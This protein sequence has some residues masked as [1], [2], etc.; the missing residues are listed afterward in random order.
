MAYRFKARRIVFD[1]D[2]TLVDTAP[3]LCRAMNHVLGEVGRPAV[4]VEQVR[5]MVGQGARKL[6]E[7]GL[8]ATGGLGPDIEIERLIAVFLDHYGANIAAASRPFDG[9][10]ALLERL[11]AQ[12]AVLGL[13]TNKPQALAEALM[14][15]LRLDGF[16]ASMVGGDALAQRKPHPMHLG[17]V[18]SDLGDGPAVMI[19]DTAT[20]VGAARNAAVPVFLA[21][22]GYSAEPA[23]S[24]GGDAVFADFHELDTWLEVTR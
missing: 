17:R 7:R 16:F 18:L 9:A 24:L 14:S 8:Q 15:E 11:S 4:P 12:G 13:C 2:G 20:D 19:G 23:V 6:I 5:H 22:F 3:D 21:A 10:V 1:L